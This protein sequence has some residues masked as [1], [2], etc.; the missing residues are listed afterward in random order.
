M[1]GKWETGNQQFLFPEELNVPDIA[2]DVDLVKHLLTE[3]R[4][5]MNGSLT[6]V[7]LNNIL[8]DVG[9][10]RKVIRAL[11]DHIVAL[12]CYA[13]DR[14]NADALLVMDGSRDDGNTLVANKELFDEWLKASEARPRLDGLKR[15]YE[16]VFTT[17]AAI[18]QTDLVE[19]QMG[20]S[21]VVQGC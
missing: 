11:K 8:V 6:S 2:T 17:E 13:D 3:P 7:A 16:V 12:E 21:D 4:R 9:K 20:T 1:S 18:P 10:C 5:S 14:D 15:A 19:K